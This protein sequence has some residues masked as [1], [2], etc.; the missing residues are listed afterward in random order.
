VIQRGPQLTAVEVKSGRRRD[1]LPGMAAFEAAHGPARKVLVGGDGTPL[2][3]FLGR[4]R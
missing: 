1:G 3:A 4:N 2:D